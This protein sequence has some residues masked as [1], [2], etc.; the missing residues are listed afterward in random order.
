MS[1]A[2][3]DIT[4]DALE[5]SRTQRLALAK[6]LLSL[7]AEETVGDVDAAWDDEIRARLKAYDEGRVEAVPYDTVRQSMIRRFAS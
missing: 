7:D 6:F 4:Y 2:L 5:L 1:R 3:Q